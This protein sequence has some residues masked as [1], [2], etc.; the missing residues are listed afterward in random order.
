MAKKLI[1][2]LMPDAHKVRSHK[3]LKFFGTLLHDPGLWHLNR[4]SVSG[5]VAVG[6]FMAFTPMP[7]QMI[8]AAVIAIIF[9][10]NLPIAVVLVWISNPL[11]VGPI[12]YFVYKLGSLLL[13]LP[14]HE[15]VFEPTWAWLMTEL[16]WIWRPILLG[17]FVVSS[18]SAT[19]GYF[20]IHALWR[21]QVIR[22]WERRKARR[23][24][25]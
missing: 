5:G 2:R 22:D 17:S 13:G 12:T 6:L 15:I 21:M 1:K 4:R 8:L 10:F 24:S 25:S 20:L 23:T 7:F 3:H 19:A 14:A 16:K 11:T 9:R 18:V